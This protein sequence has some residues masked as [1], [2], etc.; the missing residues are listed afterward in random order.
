MPVRVPDA[1]GVNVTLIVQLAEIARLEPQLFVCA[2]SPLVFTELMD[3]TFEP[4]LVNVTL[5][6]AL[7]VFSCCVVYVRLDCENV[8]A[9]ALPMP[10]NPTL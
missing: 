4:V 5:C 9:G 2:K 8:A 10:S 6:A 7:V 1:V 3:I